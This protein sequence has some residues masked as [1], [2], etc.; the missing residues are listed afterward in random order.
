MRSQTNHHSSRYS[1][2]SSNAL[3][4]VSVSILILAPLLTHLS[5][6]YATEVT[7]ELEEVTVSADFRPTTLEDSTASISVVTKEEVTKGRPAY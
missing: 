6:A 3:I 7:D 1:L 4:R 2:Y 5:V